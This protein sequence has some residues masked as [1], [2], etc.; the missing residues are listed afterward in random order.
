MELSLIHPV[1]VQTASEPSPDLPA[2]VLEL[3]EG[4]ERGL[5]SFHSR[6]AY[7]NSLLHFLSWCAV[8]QDRTLSRLTVLQYKDALIEEMKILEGGETK[9]RFA[10]ATVNQRLAAL[11]A[12]AQEAEDRGLLSSAE[13]AG[14]RR[15]RGEKGYASGVG[16]WIGKPELDRI[17]R[18]PDTTSLRGLRDYALLSTLFATGLRRGELAGLTVPSVQQRDGHWGLIDVVGKGGK[19]RSVPL[20][21]WVKDAIFEWLKAT[22]IVQGPIFRGITRHGKLGQLA[23]SEES[24][25]LILAKY[26]SKEDLP[27][28]RPHD[29]RRSCARLLR[30]AK[31]ALEDIKELLGHSSIQTTERYLGKTEGF[32]HAITDA[33]TAPGK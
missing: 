19:L 14:I 11:R 7:H 30:G 26:A 13:T 12:F 15:I 29:A 33:I 25:K 24:V 18:G 16:M 28:F 5:T 31:A 20:P 23:M 21:L 2:V 4:V 8:S 17:L 10:P 32:S 22:K 1:T 27:A 9:R 6:R 3:L